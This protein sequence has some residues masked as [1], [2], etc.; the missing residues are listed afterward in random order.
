MPFTHKLQAASKKQPAMDGSTNAFG[1]DVVST[2]DVGSSNPISA[3][4]FR[5]EKGEPCVFTYEFDEAKYFTEGQCQVEDETGAKVIAKAGD[6]MLFTK[7]STISFST[8]TYALA[9]F[10]DQRAK[11]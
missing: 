7:G 11:L 9:F 10:C 2:S 1:G 8:D 4:F 6:V 5:I 3:G